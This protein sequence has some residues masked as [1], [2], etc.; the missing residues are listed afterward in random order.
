MKAAYSV[1]AGY[2]LT[3]TAGNQVASVTPNDDPTAH[4]VVSSSAVFGP[5]QCD[6]DFTVINGTVSVARDVTVI[7]HL[8]TTSAGAP[9]DAVQASADV[10][11]TGDDNALTFTAVEYGTVGNN[12]S[13]TYADPGANDAALSVVVAGPS[14]VVNLA[15]DEAGDITS[16]AAEVLAAVGASLEA[17]RLVT[18]AI[19][20]S[21]TG[22]G[23]DGS[24]VVTAMA[25]TA[26]ENGAGT[27]VGR[28]IPGGLCIDSTNGGVYRNSGTLAAPA[29][30]QLG[31]VA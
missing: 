28:S 27:G 12:I 10:N 5:F 8:L 26:L 31:D 25:R 9:D 13:V 22:T 4:V 16:T 3:V 7:D 6:R 17:S 11:P 30:T 1:P 2:R 19:Q 24:G 18:V 15:T 23:D 14:I 20:A 21:D 29:W